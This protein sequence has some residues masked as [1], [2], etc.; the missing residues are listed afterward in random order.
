MHVERRL[1]ALG[2]ALPEVAKPKGSYRQHTRSGNLIFT[3]GHIPFDKEGNLITGTVGA[4][5]T[6]E[7]AHEAAR[8]VALSLTATLKDA[9]G[10]LD[11]VKQI[12]KL[13]GFVNSEA[14][15]TGQPGVINGASDLLYEIFGERGVHSRSAVGT[16]VLPLNVAV[17]IEAIVEVVEDV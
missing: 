12:V 10:D 13:T 5:M 17:E 1:E 8:V 7:E 14:S 16:N 11:N 2:L 6:A 3:A 4:D 9:V 15:F